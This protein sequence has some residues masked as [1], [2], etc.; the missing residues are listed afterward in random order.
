MP[1][2]TY[3]LSR[4]SRAPFSPGVIGQDRLV[5]VHNHDLSAR[6]VL[7]RCGRPCPGPGGRFGDATDYRFALG[8]RYRVGLLCGSSHRGHAEGGSFE[9]SVKPAGTLGEQIMDRLVWDRLGA[10]VLAT[11]TFAR[12]GISAV[13]CSDGPRRRGAPPARWS[14]AFAGEEL[15]AGFSRRWREDSDEQLRRVGRSVRDRGS[16]GHCDTLPHVA[17]GARV[18]SCS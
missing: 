11:N 17:R 18:A 6:G 9:C 3:G 16:D 10:H 5:D 4:R 1:S 2:P 8:A 13:P 14:A 7:L 12:P 15:A